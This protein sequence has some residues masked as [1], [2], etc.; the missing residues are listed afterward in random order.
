MDLDPKKRV[1][2]AALA[3]GEIE[4]VLTAIESGDL[5]RYDE[6]LS[7]KEAQAYS[8]LMTKNEEGRGKTILLIES[9]IK[10]QDNLRDR[11]KDLGYRVLITGNPERGLERFN[12]LDPLEESPVDCVIFSSAGLGKEAISWFE[13]FLRGNYTAQVPAILVV[14][15]NLGK[16]VR[17]EWFNEKREMLNLPVKFKHI[18]KTLRELLKIDMEALSA[19]ISETYGAEPAIPVNDIVQDT[20]V[21]L[22]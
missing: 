12:D 9:N 10:V 6:E 1:Q 21:E 19:K 3:L 7:E 20:D 18:Q 15:G 17:Q 16:L 14:T 11:L 8:S 2:S 22:G 5:K 13:K 4:A